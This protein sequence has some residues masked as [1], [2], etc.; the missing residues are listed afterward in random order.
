MRAVCA[1]M[2]HHMRTKHFPKTQMRALTN[3]VL[4][5]VA[6]HRPESVRI[7]GNPLLAT[8]GDAQEI[9]ERP[10]STGGLSREDTRCVG[11]LSEGHDPAPRDC[12]KH[13]YLGRA[14]HEDAD[15]LIAV[16]AVQAKHRKWIRMR[17]RS[18]LPGVI[19]WHH[20]IKPCSGTS[21]G[22]SSRQ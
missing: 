5:Q 9:G 17:S 3:Q 19:K 6:N 7:L 15:R 18:D 14:G 13:F 21:S 10:F 12:V 11:H 20:V 4:V 22:C 8:L 2:L 16:N 1:F